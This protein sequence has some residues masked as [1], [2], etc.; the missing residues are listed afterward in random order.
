MAGYQPLV[1]CTF[2]HVGKLA[3]AG[4]TSI[5][6][7]GTTFT[8]LFVETG[9]VSVEAGGETVDLIKGMSCL[10]PAA[11]PLFTLSGNASLLITTL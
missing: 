9:N 3:L 2:F 1:S 11:A 8:A 7:D 10:I 6:Q 5:T 4:S